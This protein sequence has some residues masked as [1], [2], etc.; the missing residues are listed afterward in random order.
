MNKDDYNGYTPLLTAVFY[1]SKE[2]VQLLLEQT[3]ASILFE[4]FIIF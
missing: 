2:C 4:I 1:N 3:Q